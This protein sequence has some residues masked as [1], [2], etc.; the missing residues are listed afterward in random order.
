MTPVDFLY[1]ELRKIAT[2]FPEVHIK[3]GFNKLICTHIV[4]MLPAEEFHSNESLDKSWIPLSFE[5]RN[6][7]A[8]EQIAFISSDSTLA[9]KEII[10]EFN[11]WN[12][13]EVMSD[14]FQELMDSE[15]DYTFPDTLPIST[16]PIESPVSEV[17]NCPIIKFDKGSE[18]EYIYQEAA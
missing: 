17:L 2:A 13:S 10:F 16:I 9:L 1:E 11:S 3:Y 12:E 15:L 7:F 6:R 5:F 4:E 14:L 8:E 18:P